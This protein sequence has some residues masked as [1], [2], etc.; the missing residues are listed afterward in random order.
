VLET[1]VNYGH[2]FRK[3]TRKPCFLQGV[4]TLRP[5]V[6]ET[7]AEAV[8]PVVYVC[9]A[10]T[11][12]DADEIHRLV[13]NQDVVPFVLVH[14]PRGVRLYSGFAYARPGVTQTPQ[15]GVLQTLTSFNQI[16][17]LVKDFNAESIDSGR[18][19]RSW[20]RQLSLDQRL[21][22]KLLG[23]LQRLDDWLQ[24]TGGLDRDVSHALIGKYV[25][26]RYLRDRDILSNR[27]LESWGIAHDSVFS[28]NANR[29]SLAALDR[30]LYN[31]LNGSI[32]PLKYSGPKAPNAEH[33]QRVAAT[34]SGDEL[35]GDSEWQ[36]HL[37]FQAYDFSYIPI[38][39]LSVIY[40]QFLHSDT[41][42]GK[43]NRGREAGAYY[44]PI[45]LVNLMLTELDERLPLR[46]GRRVLDP[47]CGSG[48]FLVQ[49][50]RRLVEAEFPANG[51]KRPTPVELR[52]LLVQ[53]IFGVDRDP[54]ACGVTELSLVLTLL[55]YVNPPDLEESPDL[56]RPKQFK[57]PKL[58]DRNVI[59]SNL[60]PPKNDKLAAI[61][62]RKFDWVVGN[63][64][65]K[66][67]NPKKL[68]PEDKP[69]WAW[70]KDNGSTEDTPVGG[71][72]M[73]QAFVW[74]VRTYLSADGEAAFLLPAMI[75]FEDQSR[76]FRSAFFRQHDVRTVV[77]LAN[78]TELL[79]VGRSRKKTARVPAAAVFFSLNDT[80]AEPTGFVTT[81]SPLVANQESTR[82]RSDGV[83]QQLWNLTV[84][85]SDIRDVSLAEIADGDGLPWKLAT[86][87][88]Q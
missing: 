32:F 61:H 37:D 87:G 82:E 76:R 34:F 36:L 30:K 19:W 88:S 7:R 41:D 1:T 49:C 46:R 33:I 80:D 35:V 68:I 83:R 14:T 16:A 77:N 39:T 58:R 51:R 2:I 26:L 72:R 15:S 64:P 22:W 70:I 25:F 24:K 67:L 59:C 85:G 57:L 38:E 9:Q 69:V 17:G 53:H 50:F 20:G 86:W 3:A 81:Y 6:A 13:W 11:E 27:K 21:D 48:A 52:D 12:Q 75:L 74:Q 10:K 43:N 66:P 55:D 47:A 71:N 65:W 60:F 56:Q 54:D 40:E 29:A 23:N 42:D 63:P 31:W 78:L 4:Y 45:P 44:T 18:L 62:R 8:V 73:S 28:R 5:E 84:N 79:F